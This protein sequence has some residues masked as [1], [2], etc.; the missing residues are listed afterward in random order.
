MKK[1]LASIIM[2]AAVVMC[3]FTFAGCEKELD[4]NGTYKLVYALY[5][6]QGNIEVFNDETSNIET[7]I[8]INGTTI[9]EFNFKK[10]D[11]QAKNLISMQSTTHLNL[12][13]FVVTKEDGVDYFTN[14][15]NLGKYEENKNINKIERWSF[16]KVDSIPKIVQNELVGYF[17]EYNLTTRYVGGKP[18]TNVSNLKLI[19]N[20]NLTFVEDG[21]ETVYTFEE[22]KNG[23]YS[24]VYN[25]TKINLAIVDGK[26][27]T[28]ASTENSST[29]YNLYTKIVEEEK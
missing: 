28:F 29:D 20:G 11:A 10:S 5:S 1:F 22:I 19:V 2:C 27:R 18:Q 8:K 6:E 16:V 13:E 9:T 24:Y 21:N 26:V 15:D 12:P 4:M 14:F 3:I 7:Y 17:G 23:V 25:N